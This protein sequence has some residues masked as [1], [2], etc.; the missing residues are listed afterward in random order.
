MKTPRFP[1]SLLVAFLA[2]LLFDRVTKSWAMQALHFGSSVPVLGG[3][4]SFTLTL[5]TGAAFSILSGKNTFLI[6]LSVVVIIFIIYTSFRLPATVLTRSAV[7]LILGGAVSNL[8]DRLAYGSIVDF[9]NFHIWPVFN[10]ADAAI[11]VGVL[12][13]IAYYAQEYFSPQKTPRRARKR[14]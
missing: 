14:T 4:L 6:V 3:L 5:N 9:I 7:G 10:L 12:L 2:A 8:F 11:S 1:L 13:L